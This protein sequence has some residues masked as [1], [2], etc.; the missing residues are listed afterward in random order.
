M[1]H[2]VIE[3]A[4]EVE[5]QID[6]SE[7]LEV[8]HQVGA[9]SGLMKPEDIKVR[10]RPYDHYRKDVRKGEHPFLMTI[11]P[12]LGNIMLERRP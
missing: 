7:L 9:S 6:L 2:F 5:Q 12:K 8:T 3:Y 11:H 1:P 4:R 10:A